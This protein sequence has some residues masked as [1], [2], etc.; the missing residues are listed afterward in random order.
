MDTSRNEPKGVAL[1]PER[2]PQSFLWETPPVVLLPG[3]GPAPAHATQETTSP[4]GRL[5]K[6]PS[7]FWLASHPPPVLALQVHWE[8]DPATSPHDSLEA[9]RPIPAGDGRSAMKSK[10]KSLGPRQALQGQPWAE[11]RKAREWKGPGTG[12]GAP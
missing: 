11:A 8:S 12:T 1:G 2:P 3:C 6:S 5:E 9:P 7:S 10:K 4:S